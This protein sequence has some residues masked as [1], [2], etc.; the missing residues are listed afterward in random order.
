MGTKILVACCVFDERSCVPLDFCEDIEIALVATLDNRGN[1]IKPGVVSNEG[2]LVRH[3]LTLLSVLKKS[4][5]IALPF[6]A[7]SEKGNANEAG[8]HDFVVYFGPNI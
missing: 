3:F 2:K 4:L 8:P 5:L 6:G 7:F 1:W